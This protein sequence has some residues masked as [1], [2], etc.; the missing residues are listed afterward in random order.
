MRCEDVRPLLSAGLDEELE[1]GCAAQVRAHLA[2]CASCAI[3]RQALDVTVR[4]LRAVPEVD[5]PAELRR[6]IGVAL[7]EEVRRRSGRRSLLAPLGLG[8]P[9]G[10]GSTCAVVI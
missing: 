1:E 5:P 6:R 7:H 4:L 2:G 9:R 3:E 10:T 8:L